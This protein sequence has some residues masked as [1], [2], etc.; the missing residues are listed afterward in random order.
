MAKVGVSN[1]VLSQGL[2]NYQQQQK[3][4]NATNT[5]PKVSNV[6]GNRPPR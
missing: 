2:A 5:C 6:G 1:G 3:C 4:R